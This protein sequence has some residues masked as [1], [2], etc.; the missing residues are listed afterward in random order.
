MFRQTL[1]KVSNVASS[2]RTLKTAPVLSIE[3]SFC[4]VQLLGRIGADP[5]II[6]TGNRE[7][8]LFNVAV[9]I[10][11]KKLDPAG[12]TSDPEADNIHQY[13]HWHAVVVRRPTL[14]THVLKNFFKGTRVLCNGVL[15]LKTQ[16]GS[17]RPSYTVVLDEITN[18]GHPSQRQNLSES[19][20]DKNESSETDNADTA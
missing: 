19:S 11:A 7:V 5:K 1:F 12:E 9:N 6:S 8:V 10:M 18:L 15:A 17:N 13:T 16:E 4:K 14:Q 20:E 2:I 3:K